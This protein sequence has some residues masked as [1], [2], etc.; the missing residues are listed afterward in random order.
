MLRGMFDLG[1]DGF[2]IVGFLFG[3]LVLGDEFAR[4]GVPEEGF[5]SRV[6]GGESLATRDKFGDFKH[7]K[8]I[9]QK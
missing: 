7:T 9:A 3:D 4:E 2:E 6:G 1:G 8:I 5:L